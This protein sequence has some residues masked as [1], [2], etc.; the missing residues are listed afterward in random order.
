MV[1]IMVLCFN[2]FIKIYSYHVDVDIYSGV[3]TSTCFFS[4]GDLVIFLYGLLS[5]DTYLLCIDRARL[6]SFDLCW[7]EFAGQREHFGSMP[8]EPDRLNW[9]AVAPCAPLVFDA[10][11]PG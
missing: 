11:L 2:K 9:L 1:R 3:L 6:N 5:N 7:L 4:I 8:F 10:S